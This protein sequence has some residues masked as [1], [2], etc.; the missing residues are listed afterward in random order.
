MPWD[1]ADTVADSAAYVVLAH[2]G[3]DASGYTFPYVARWAEDRAALTRIL[4]AIQ[5]TG[6]AIIS[7]IGS[8]ETI[9]AIEMSARPTPTPHYDQTDAGR[10]EGS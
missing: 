8:I 7:G 2:Y 5:Q 6:H 3:I 9:E 10:G 1:D 4:A